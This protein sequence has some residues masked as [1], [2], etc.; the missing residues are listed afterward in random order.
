MIQEL[1]EGFRNKLGL[2]QEQMDILKVVLMF[3]LIITM[4]VMTI[5][6]WKYGSTIKA[7]PCKYCDCISK[8]LKGGTK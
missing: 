2:T 4:I 7:D 8:V 1:E 5:V 3:G 6:I